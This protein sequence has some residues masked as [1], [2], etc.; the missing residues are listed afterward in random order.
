M[1]NSRA[2]VPIVLTSS[3]P[4]LLGGPLALAH[5]GAWLAALYCIGWLLSGAYAY[6][7]LARVGLGVDPRVGFLEPLLPTLAAGCAAAWAGGLR[8]AGA[9]GGYALAA[10][11][12]I[13]LS[14]A[15][16]RMGGHQGRG[17]GTFV[18]NR[19]PGSAPTTGARDG[20]DRWRSTRAHGTALA[21]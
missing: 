5:G 16:Y 7:L 15:V 18:P 2:S 11:L 3:L 20:A 4:L 17:A 19:R 9:W 8:G 1:G 6:R 14:L 13:G 10:C 21:E 12:L